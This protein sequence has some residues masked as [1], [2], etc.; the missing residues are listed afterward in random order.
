MAPQFLLKPFPNSDSKGNFAGEC[1]AP[2]NIASVGNCS[3]RGRWHPNHFWSRWQVAARWLPNF[4]R[5]TSLIQ[6]QKEMALEEAVGLVCVCVC[7]CLGVWGVGVGWLIC[8]CICEPVCVGA[9]RSKCVC[10]CLCLCACVCVCL[11]ACEVGEGAGSSVPVCVSVCVFVSA[12]LYVYVFVGWV[13]SWQFCVGVCLCLCAEVSECVV[14]CVNRSVSSYVH[15]CFCVSVC[16][17]VSG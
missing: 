3:G 16:T 7:A 12:Y 2:F 8:A 4:L 15:V 6:I 13:E 17:C 5:S 14:G 9:G 1:K 11:G 10:V